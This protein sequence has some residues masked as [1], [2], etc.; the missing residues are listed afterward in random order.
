MMSKSKIKNRIIS[1]VLALVVMLEMFIPANF[2]IFAEENYVY[3]GGAGTNVVSDLDTS[4]KYSESLGDNASTEY[5]GRIWS[6]KSV[7]SSDAVFNTYGGGKSTIV[8]NENNNGEDFL[9]AFS[10]LATSESIEGESQAPVDV[11]LILDISGSMS[12]SESNMDNNKSR[13]YNTIQAANNAIDRLMSLN[14]YTR[15]AVVAFS[16]NATT[17]LPLDRYTKATTIEREWVQTGVF[18]WQGYWK[19]TEVVVPYFSLNN[20]TGSDDYAVLYTKAVNPDNNLIE[21]STDVE[22]GTN[23]QMGLYEGMKILAEEKS[24]KALIDGSEIQRVPSVILLSDGSPTYSSDS[25]SWWKP[26]DNYNDGPGSNPYAGNGMKAILVGSYMKD[27]I[28]RNYGVTGTAYGTTVYTVGMGITGLPENEK[29]LANMTLNP[30]EYWNNNSV[31]NTM[32]TIIRDYW[33]EYTKNNNTGTLNINVGKLEQKNNS[34]QYVDKNYMLTHPDTG[35]DVNPTTGYDYVDDYYDAD[36]ASAVMDVF[37]QIV[38]SISI[39]APQVPTEIKGGDPISDGYITYTDPIGEYME[40]KD[41]KAIIYAG[42]TFTQKSSS[43][44]GNVTTYVFSGTVESA[45]YG[46][47]EIKDIIIQVTEI[48]GKQTL[49]VKIPASVIPLRVNSVSLNTDGSV[50]SHTNNGAYPAR[51]I[52]SVGLKDEILKESDS[53]VVYLDKTKISE[54][55]LNNNTNAD[56]TV[57]FYS[58]IFNG[59]KVVN[60]STAGNATVEF[61]P[62]HTNKFYYILEDKPIY[63]DE[64]L[65][66]KLKASDGIDENK[67]YYI[68]DEY[69][70]G[71]SV[72]IDAIPRT[73][74]Q[75]NSTS[76]ISGEDGLLYR[77]KGSPNLNRI[78]KFEGTK[79]RNATTT[80]EDF[81]APTFEYLEGSSDPFE[82]KFV[83]Y[84]GNNGK[85]SM[86]A[87]GNLQIAKTV[88]AGIGL[89]APDKTFEFTLDLDGNNVNQGVFDYAIV[90]E[91]G[92]TVEIGTV[93]K[94]NTVIKLKDGQIA[95]VYSL[96][97]GTTYKVTEKAVEG[98]TSESQGA[99]GTITAG[100]TSEVSFTNTYN[101]EPVIF[102]ANGSLTGEKELVGRP[103]DDNDTFTFIISPYNNAPLPVNYDGTKGVVITKADAVNGIAEFD[104]GKIEF[105]APGTYRYTIYEDEPDNNAY[106]PG[107]SYSRALYRLVVEVV[108]NGDGKL[109]IKSSDVQRLYDDDANPLFT[110]NNDNEI[111]MNQGQEGQDGIKF[112]NTYSADSVVRVPVALKDYI[113]N[114]GLNPLVSG[115]FEFKFKALG[116]LDDSGALVETYTNIPMP[117]GSTNGESVTTNEGHNITFLPVEFTQDV[118]PA[119]KN[120]ITFRYSMSEVIPSQ[121]VNGMKY[122]DTEYIIDVTV[123]IDPNSDELIVNS[124]YPGGVNIVTFKNEYTPVPVKTDIDGNKTLNG[125]DMK[126]G[127]VFSFELSGANAATNNAVRNG[128]VVIPSGV[129]TVMDGNDGEKVKFAFEDIQFAKAGTY[130]FNVTEVVGSAPAVSYD[131]SVITVTIVV[132]DADK[133]GNL[134]IKSITYS[135]GKNAAEFVNEYTTEFEGTPISLYGT[136]NLTGKSLLEG[137]FFFNVFEYFNGTKVSEGLVSH[138]VDTT[139]INDVYTGTITFFENVT[140]TEAGKYEYY[141]TEQIPVNKVV[142]TTYD[143]TEY[144]Y[145]VVVEDEDKIG[146]LTVTSATLEVMDN[147]FWKASNGV[148]FENDYK[149]NPTAVS[150]PIINKVI[151]GD[152]SE[153]LKAGDFEFELSLDSANPIDGIILP[154]TTVVSNAANGQIV[155]DEITFTKA[156]KYVVAVNE[157]M[158]TRPIPGIT[159]SNQT[160]TAEFNVVDD[161]NGNLTATLVNFVGGDTIVNTYKAETVEIEV[162]IHKNFTGRNNDEWLATDKFDFEVVILDPATQSAVKNGDI[163]FPMDNEDDITVKTIDTK[164][165]TVTGKVKVNTPGTYKFIVREITGN[166]PGVHYDSQPREIVVVATDNSAEAKLDITINGDAVNSIDL[167]FN[168]VYDPSSTE[169]SGHD[170]LTISKSFTGRQNDVW[171]DSD[172]FVFTLDSGDDTTSAAISSGDVEMPAELE[173]TV[174]NANKAHPHFGNIVFHE[175]GTYKFKITEKDGKLSYI[176]YDLTPRYVIVE[177]TNDASTGNLVAKVADGSDSLTFSNVYKTEAAVLEGK[178]NLVVVKSLTG[179]DWFGSDN[180]RFTIAPFGRVTAGAIDEGV[181]VMP[182]MS[183]ITINTLDSVHEHGYQDAFGDIVF[184]KAGTYRF[185]IKE[186]VGDIHN[187][188]YDHHTYYVTVVVTDNNEGKLVAKPIYESSKVFENIYEPD[189][190]TQPIKGEKVLNGNRELKADD[191]EFVITAVTNRAPMPRNNKVTNDADGNVDF[192]EITF[193]EEGTYVYEITEVKG[194]IKGVSYDQKKVTVTVEVTYNQSTGKFSATV[195]YVKEGESAKASFKFENN[196]K[197]EDS[198]T[199]DLK[200]KKK[201]TASEGNSFTLKG[202]EFTFVIEGSS[203]APMPANTTV[204]NDKN[205]NVDFGSVNFIDAG[206]FTYTVREVQGSLNGFSYDESVYTITVIATD[207]TV[208]AKIVTS[209]KVTDSEDKETEAVF[210]NKYNPKETS[211][212]IFGNKVLDSRHKELE[213]GEFEFVIKAVT[214]NAPLPKETT[215]TNEASGLFKFEAIE[216]TKVGTYV[217]E[218]TEKNTG[219][220]GYTYDNTVYTVTVTV[221]DEG[222]GQLNAEVEGVEK[223]NGDAAI[224]FE[225]KYKAAASVPVKLN[226][227]KKVKAS[228]GNSFTLKGGEFTF[229][230]EGSNGAPMPVNTTVTNDADGNIDFGSVKFAD[231]GTFTYTIREVQGERGGFVYDGAVYTITVM[232]RVELRDAEI[233]TSVKVTDSEDK[234]AE[235]LFENKYNPKETSAVIFGNKVLDSKHKELEAGE[236]EFVIKAVTEDAPL[237]KETTVTNA[238]NGLFQFEAIEYTKV[239]TYVYE[240]TEKNTGKKGYTYDDTVYTVTVTVTDEGAGQLNAEVEGVEKAN[241]DAAINFENKYKAEASVPV[242]FNAKKKVKPSEGNSFTL[243]GGEFTFVIEGS[244]GAPMPVNTTVTNDADGNIDFGSVKFEDV[245]TFTYTVREVLENRGGFTYDESVYT[246]TVVTKVDF[247]DAKIVTSVKVT[248]EDNQDAEVVFENKYDPKETPVVVYGNKVLNSEHKELEAGEFEFV[249]TAVTENAPLPKETT[250]TNEASGLFKF[251]AIEYTKVGTYVYE[252]TEKN[253]GKKGYTYDDTVYTVTVTVTDEGAGQL[254]AKVDGVELEQN[255]PAIKFTNSYVPKDVDLVIGKDGE[256]NKV[257]DGRVIRD[258][259]F[260]FALFDVNGDEIAKSKNDENGKFKFG[261][262]YTKAG[263]YN[264]TIVEMNNEVAGVKYDEKVFDVEVKVVDNNGEL[265]VES[266]VYTLENETVDNVTFN[267]IYKAAPTDISLEATKILTGRYLLDGE[268]KFV[269]ATENGDVVTAATN[270]ADGEISFDKIYFDG[271]GVYKFVVYEEKGDLAH[272]VYDTTKYIV[273]IEVTD[274]GKGQLKASEPVIKSEDG[275]ETVEKIVFENTFEVSVQNPETGDS[276]N[277]FLWLALFVVSG[278]GITATVVFGRRR[279]NES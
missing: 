264:Y 274:D 209:V 261:I 58:N 65:T 249:I 185:D 72:E 53:G 100:N 116:Y 214:E 107:L 49:V 279:E 256:L 248:D 146:K 37:N 244:N 120:S 81:Y 19:E 255:V 69:Y 158:P 135:N 82:G 201:V 176:K 183:E 260:E 27:A 229:V 32:K 79:I 11:V 211:A 48:N 179:R 224:N 233:V 252:I 96:P 47:Q 5:A 171:L 196:Y 245:G 187:V 242:E 36:N 144:R 4:D 206:T 275:K 106:L 160:I 95:T 166:I 270:N 220:K 98:F 139:A 177:V 108:D 168:N 52:Y 86:V 60:G 181:V 157:V 199:V 80:A 218:I 195:S 212:V 34:W 219:K 186:S 99:T 89:T 236:F 29:N 208:N 119:G 243:K 110:Y 266:V 67:T 246:I 31:S 77:E 84:L 231:V 155:F 8:L 90:D 23:I 64:T 14:E 228:E 41:V 25:A 140:Y 57:N 271:P 197:A 3:K 76:L 223:A 142:G 114:S 239:G 207:D 92:N 63:T 169:L 85:M 276:S 143:E 241:G 12:N 150:L 103:W 193:T 235:V 205:G 165:E 240:I 131:N 167:T 149:P 163:E 267:N 170:N 28:D 156:G 61:E 44:A 74:A 46:H 6:D 40:V 22:G 237:P 130:T 251:E 269:I 128:L 254:E 178:T 148:L 105:T 42:Q 180:F 97:P 121:K 13:I 230:I 39:A 124:V 202:G 273:V 182:A 56:G 109:S 112:V 123:S 141:I 200:V 115:M 198:E 194:D 253:T 147:G 26:Q 9:V 62:S 7:Y 55:Y 38:S 16:S 94:E 172:K 111:V 250:I 137:E 15:V 216:Y 247:N 152:R 51:V 189:P 24:T 161:R 30:G 204:T 159:Y 191:F 71:A 136:K 188:E 226:A 225:N 268:F 173:L 101:V 118:I 133:D 59:E 162:E 50:K 217:Y 1:F 33:S 18:S 175:E 93:S 221:T 117:E 227:K 257:L 78:L 154:T 125:R 83:V 213:A 277:L 88:N 10:A 35:Y 66:N 91:A 70:H 278:V 126:A 151:A 138:T 2:S 129:A 174:S 164:G 43:A 113:D 153:S 134:E 203:G 238:A 222:S 262:N 21:K 190:V 45:V 102:P 263:T 234:E 73:G 258:E 68:L 215:V 232:T 184:K 127:E 210:D 132:D 145:T 265:K 20:D 75:L 122:D 54:V 104:F 87:G 272:V 192:G 259:E 17:L